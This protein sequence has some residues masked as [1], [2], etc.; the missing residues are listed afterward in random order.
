M[1][2]KRTSHTTKSKVN[3]GLVVLWVIYG[4]VLAAMD[5]S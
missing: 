3:C 5:D 4:V 1:E 2:E